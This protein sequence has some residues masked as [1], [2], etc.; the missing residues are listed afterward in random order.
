ML[1][2]SLESKRRDKAEVLV[3]L[4]TTSQTHNV[5]EYMKEIIH[6][7]ETDFKLMKLISVALYVRNFVTFGIYIFTF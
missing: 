5:Y 6:R 4:N 3:I 2:S 1:W 7:N